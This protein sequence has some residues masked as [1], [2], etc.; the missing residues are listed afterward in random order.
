MASG[1]ETIALGAS[2]SIVK[3]VLN[4]IHAFCKSKIKREFRFLKYQKTLDELVR[5]IQDLDQVRT[6]LQ[7]EII[8]SLKKIYYPAR[9]VDY[10][11]PAGSRRGLEIGSLRELPQENY[12][13]EGT[14]G[15]GKTCFLKHLALGE[16]SERASSDN[17]R[18]PVFIELRNIES[19][20]EE[21]LVK[22]LGLIAP[23][24][25]LDDLVEMAKSGRMVL[26]LDAFDE[27]P[28]ELQQ[29]V[30][31]E[32]SN[33]AKRSPALQQIITT[34]AGTPLSTCT[35]FRTMKL[36]EL[37]STDHKLFLS[38]VLGDEKTADKVITE[39]RNSGVQVSNLLTTPLLLTLLAMLYQAEQMI[40][41]TVHEFYRHLFDTLFHRHD[42]M[43]EGYERKRQTTLSESDFKSLFEACCFQ[44]SIHNLGTFDKDA[45][46]D[47]VARAQEVRAVQVDP[48]KFR[49]DCVRS[50]CLLQ[51][52][53]L[54]YHFIH[55]SVQ[56]YYAASF[57]QNSEDAFAKKWY[58]AVSNNRCTQFS[59]ELAF[60]DEIDRGRFARFFWVPMFEALC[61]QVSQIDIHTDKSGAIA[62][63][64]KQF[65]VTLVER[66]EGRDRKAYRPVVL[67]PLGGDAKLL[68]FQ[69]ATF[70]PL[71]QRH[72]TARQLLAANR[73]VAAAVF[74]LT[75]KSKD[76]EPIEINAIMLNTY[77][78][79]DQDP[80][81]AEQEWNAL[82]DIVSKRYAN[83]RAAIEAEQKKLDLLTAFSRR[84]LKTPTSR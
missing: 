12:I 10:Q 25:T 81:K 7:P 21:L 45:F 40:P 43:K 5:Q 74:P 32:V 57:V 54:R 64:L 46:R 26:L 38:R 80:K 50:L 73:E 60:L 59:Q 68:D 42:R 29:R 22:R 84:K 52:E 65:A 77:I 16:L 2:A 63:L 66:V 70:Q 28:P 35:G 76:R 19:S 9:V 69:W 78:A 51:E 31:T 3:G 18:I 33:L 39:V 79:L 71:L 55:R 34:R 83:M 36:E 15:Q 61:K 44:S 53:G 13:I 37:R 41:P 17:R 20:L 58:K 75:I 6:I 62:A 23:S 48:D 4:D 1:L 24:L 82:V 67:F 14:I 49:E 72:L 47:C 8:K 11:M 27:I 56:E 30:V